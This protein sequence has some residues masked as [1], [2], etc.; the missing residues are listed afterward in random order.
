[1]SKSLRTVVFEAHTDTEAF[2]VLNSGQLI[3]QWLHSKRFGDP[4]PMVT[5]LLIQPLV[6]H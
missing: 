4:D 3:L 6:L 1:M 2:S 5:L